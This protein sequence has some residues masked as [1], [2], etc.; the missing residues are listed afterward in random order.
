MS[1]PRLQS[2][3]K[4]NIY[5]KSPSAVC[6]PP[7]LGLPPVTPPDGRRPFPPWLRTTAALPPSG[8]FNDAS[9]MWVSLLGLGILRCVTYVQ[10]GLLAMFS[11][12]RRRA[13]FVLQR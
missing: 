7:G 4:S 3:G 13:W 12:P 10:G 6:S 11:E 9:G 1:N 8:G 5:T 2:E